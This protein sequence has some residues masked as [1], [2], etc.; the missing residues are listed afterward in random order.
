M[1]LGR[2][3]GR[4]TLDKVEGFST[5]IGKDSHFIGTIGGA[6]NFIIQ[7]KVEGDCNIEG[8]LVIA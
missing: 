2:S 7:G 4:R 6:G 8:T 1:N 3:K 5:V